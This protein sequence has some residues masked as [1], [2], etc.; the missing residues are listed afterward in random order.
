MTISRRGSTIIAGVCAAGLAS[1]ADAVAGAEDAAQA[2]ICKRMLDAMA[3]GDPEHATDIMMLEGQPGDVRVSREGNANMA[4]LRTVT[5][6]IYD[7][8]IERSG[9]K[10]QAR[11]PLPE[12]KLGERTAVLERWDFGNGRKLYADCV[13]YPE[14]ASS[15]IWGSNMQ[16]GADEATVTS[17]LHDAAA[18]K[19]DPAP[20]K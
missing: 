18:G 13:R 19:P 9:G 5:R 1:G 4:K 7:G 15:N 14:K 12:R 16:F 8:V 20:P 11:E 10:P 6:R 3:S 17:K 2:Q